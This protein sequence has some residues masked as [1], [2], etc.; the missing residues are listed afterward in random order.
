LQPG[1]RVWYNVTRIRPR[2]LAPCNT[3][4]ERTILETGGIDNHE[5]W[6]VDAPGWLAGGP[7]AARAR[8]GAA[9]GGDSPAVE[10]YGLSAVE[11]TLDLA[12]VYPGVFDGSF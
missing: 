3:V 7:A 11:L 5:A 10:G 8:P 6:S 4:R 2:C 12:L 1:F 9:P